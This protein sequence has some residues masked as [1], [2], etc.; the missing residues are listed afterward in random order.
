MAKTLQALA[1]VAYLQA[2]LETGRDHIGLL[3]PLVGDTLIAVIGNDFAPA[4]VQ[5]AL[6]ERTGIQVPIDAIRT[7]LGRFVKRGQLAREGGRYLKT[8]VPITS[9]DFDS[10]RNSHV[11]SIR[12]LG[13]RLLAF[14]QE[15]GAKLDSVERAVELLVQFISDHRVE[16]A[17]NESVDGDTPQLTKE[18]RRQ[19]R[20]VARFISE[21]CLPDAECATSLRRLVEGTILKSALLLDD[22]ADLDRR[23][24]DMKIVIDTSVLISALGLAGDAEKRAV[25]EGLRLLKWSGAQCLVF[26]STLS[27]LSGIL[28]SYIARL[29]S[30]KRILE[31]KQSAMTQHFISSRMTSATLRVISST[32][33]ARCRQLGLQIAMPVSRIASYVLDEQDLAHR[34]RNPNDRRDQESRI[35]HDVNIVGT[36]LTWR[37]GV[38]PTS[39]SRCSAVMATTSTSVLETVRDWFLG[40]GHT[41]HQVPPAV[42]FRKLTALAWLKRPAVAKDVKIHEL[43]ALC[44]ALQRPDFRTWA[45]FVE[46]LGTLRSEGA[47]TDGETATLV[48]SDLLQAQ[49][50]H[51]EDIGLDQDSDSMYQAI[52]RT[53]EEYRQEGRKEGEEKAKNAIAE[54]ERQSKRLEQID[55]RLIAP[56]SQG[57]AHVVGALL[58]LAAAVGFFGQVLGIEFLKRV[59]PRP[60]AYA[61]LI[62]FAMLTTFSLVRGGTILHWVRVVR[63]KMHAAITAA[64]FGPVDA[65]ENDK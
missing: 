18:E 9:E 2:R 63:S 25:T 41:E 4:E 39:L 12:H 57:L 61:G 36:V 32:L 55:K 64:L 56:V 50:A 45:K 58:A 34:L 11:Q 52:E 49:L 30:P 29:D 8:E 22:F 51:L 40:Q 5:T 65:S 28:S 16:L 53:R 46:V 47:I 20:I 35:W 17:L 6:V 59:L 43:V 7:L 21:H 14:A 26:E 10:E 48:T 31:L 38:H 42:H 23:L 33:A 19:Y 15:N 24:N 3:E 27:E 1:T 60:I 62:L 54:A 37:Q 44:A 13:A